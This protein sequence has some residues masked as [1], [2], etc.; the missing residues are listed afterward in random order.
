MINSYHL[1]S[2]AKN[3][4]CNKINELSAPMCAETMNK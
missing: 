4:D 1:F 3:F 2:N